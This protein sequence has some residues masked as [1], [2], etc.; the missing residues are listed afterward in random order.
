MTDLEL[1]PM[2]NQPT[3]QHVI[4][5][6][7]RALARTIRGEHFVETRGI[8]QLKRYQRAIAHLERAEESLRFAIAVLTL[9]AHQE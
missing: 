6:L 9:L 1:S 2:N 8:G 5:H 4:F 3:R 7:D